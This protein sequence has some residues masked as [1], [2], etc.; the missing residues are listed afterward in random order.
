M[1]KTIPNHLDGGA[2]ANGAAIRHARR[3][4]CARLS[5]TADPACTADAI[6]IHEFPALIKAVEALFRHEETVMESLDYA[7]L[8]EHLAENAIILTALHRTLPAVED[9][10]VALGRQLVA[11]LLD[12]LSL[13]RISTDLALATAPHQARGRPGG[14][15]ARSLLHRAFTS[16]RRAGAG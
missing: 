5:T 10:D 7:R 13:H 2:G 3:R 11:A 14:R 4:L 16:S 8:H 6:F 9:G 15:V 12:V 1:F